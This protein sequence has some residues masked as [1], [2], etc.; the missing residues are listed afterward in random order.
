MMKERIYFV[1]V[2]EVVVTYE[3]LISVVAVNEIGIALEL[4][5]FDK[6]SVFL[7]CVVELGRIW[8][9]VIEKN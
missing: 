9:G 1:D 8:N 7:E 3:E 4:F 6:V 2:F 5:D